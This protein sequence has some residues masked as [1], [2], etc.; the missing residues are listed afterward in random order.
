MN[1]APDPRPSKVTHLPN[2][3][4]QRSPAR[5]RRQLRTLVITIVLLLAV[6]LLLMWM[7]SSDQKSVN[8]SAPSSTAEQLD[9]KYD[10]SISHGKLKEQL[11]QF[12]A[13]TGIRL[14]TIPT[15][16][17]IFTEDDGIT[18]RVSGQRALMTLLGK[19][20]CG[21]TTEVDAV[22]L[23]CSMDRAEFNIPAQ[24]LRQALDVFMNE[25]GMS[26]VF[27]PGIIAGTEQSTGVSGVHNRRNALQLLLRDTELEPVFFRSN[28]ALIKKAS[29]K[30]S[31]NPSGTAPGGS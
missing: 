3:H 8:T 7:L 21:F 1:T 16:I 13:T 5:N 19:S 22:S 4:K 26:I 27:N 12:Q 2:A 30:S 25:T 23:R 24:P 9:R 11:D 18:G 20:D 6:A 14:A 10:F 17:E 31:Q 29:P 15:E 28:I